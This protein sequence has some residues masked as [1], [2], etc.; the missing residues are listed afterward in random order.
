M[1]QLKQ[2]LSKRRNAGFGFTVIG[3]CLPITENRPNLTLCLNEQPI[4]GLLDTGADVTVLPISVWACAWRLQRVTLV[5]GIGGNN[6]QVSKS[7][8]WLRCSALSNEQVITHIQP[9]VMAIYFP[10]W[11][12]D[13]LHKLHVSVELSFL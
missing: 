5:Q 7:S 11:G 6:K 8:L 12:R 10:I 13:I 3:T 2:S 1:L 9:Y 4:T